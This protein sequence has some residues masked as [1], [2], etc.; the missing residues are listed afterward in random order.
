ML[1]DLSTEVQESFKMRD[2]SI[3]EQIRLELE[4]QNK[5]RAKAKLNKPAIN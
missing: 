5:E 2:A 3:H 4:T 1:D